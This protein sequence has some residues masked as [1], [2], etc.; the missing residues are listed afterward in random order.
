[1][2]YITQFHIEVE[3]SDDS[4]IAGLDSF[5]NGSDFSGYQYDR[6]RESVWY[7]EGK[8]GDW[9]D[10]MILLSTRFPGL[11]FVVDGDGD[12][13]DDLWR[14]YVLDGK[15]VQHAAIIDFPP[16]FWEVEGVRETGDSSQVGVLGSYTTKDGWKLIAFDTPYLSWGL[17]IQNPDGEDVYSNASTFDCFAY[18]QHF[19]E[20]DSN[21]KGVPW[22]PEEWAE[23]LEDEAELLLDAYTRAE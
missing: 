4:I 14:A 21:P 8:W 17:T 19:D 18:G 9:E 6:I 11:R 12:S 20:D 5:L 13:Q 22:T 15:L 7:C 23:C 10:H 2:G 1:M 3:T 16:P